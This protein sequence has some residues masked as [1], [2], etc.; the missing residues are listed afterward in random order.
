MRELIGIVFGDIAV[1]CVPFSMV[2]HSLGCVIWPV[3]LIGI[4]CGLIAFAVD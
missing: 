1:L 2:M 4:V 3:V